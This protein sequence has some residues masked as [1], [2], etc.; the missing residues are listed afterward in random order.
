MFSLKLNYEKDYGYYFFDFRSIACHLIISFPEGSKR[1]LK[2]FE[3]SEGEKKSV[4]R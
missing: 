4:S 1:I 2:F 3:I